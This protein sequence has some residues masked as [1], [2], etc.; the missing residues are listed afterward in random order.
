MNDFEMPIDHSKQPGGVGFPVKWR[1]ITDPDLLTSIENVEAQQESPLVMH[2]C[3]ATQFS[4]C[5]HCRGRLRKMRL[6]HK[7]LTPRY[8]VSYCSCDA[9]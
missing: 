1:I 9:W 2:H 7:T 4:F 8:V 3:P 6:W 5:A